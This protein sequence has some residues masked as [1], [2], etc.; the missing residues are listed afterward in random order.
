MFTKQF[1]NEIKQKLLLQKNELLKKSNENIDVDKDGDEFDEIQ[2]NMLIEMHNQLSTRN[3]NALIKIENSL[4]QID[5]NEYGIC[6]D[7]GDCI[8]EKRLLINPYTD[9]CIGC[10]EEREFEAKQRKRD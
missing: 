8:S 1:L 2:G 3:I 5:S 4:K 6:Q 10:A 7:C 9:I